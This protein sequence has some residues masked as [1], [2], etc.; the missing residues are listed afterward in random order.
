MCAIC[1]EAICSGTCLNK[2]EDYGN[3]YE[4]SLKYHFNSCI[5]VSCTTTS[6]IIYYCGFYHF[7]GKL[8]CDGLGKNLD[9]YDQKLTEIKWESYK[10]N[11]YLKNQIEHLI[12]T[13]NIPSKIGSKIAL[14]QNEI[15]FDSEL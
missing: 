1:N 4:H 13:N 3:L 5:Y 15:K 10:V 11:K 9:I 7:L 8:Y 12:N 14:N 2:Y 6:I